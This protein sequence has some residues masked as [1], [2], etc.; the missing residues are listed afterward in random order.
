MNMNKKFIFLVLLFIA[1]LAY[2]LWPVCRPYQCKCPE[3]ALCKCAETKE[4]F[5]NLISSINY[6]IKF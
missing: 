3:N 1:M 6:G 4:C 2:A 5:A